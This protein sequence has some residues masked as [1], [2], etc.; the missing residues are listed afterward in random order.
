[1]SNEE[2]T[3][4]SATPSARSGRWDWLWPSIA[5]VVIMKIFG[6]A[7][8]LV[9][10]GV[11]YWMKPKVGTWGAVAIAAVAGIV[12]AIVLMAAIRG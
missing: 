6:V 9:T 8:G 5:A 2:I 4:Q 12:S 11:F 10:F 1:M 3:S 7:G